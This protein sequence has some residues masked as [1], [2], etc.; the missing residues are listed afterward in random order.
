MGSSFPL[1]EDYRGRDFTVTVR[2]DLKALR[3]R[4]LLRWLL[5]REAKSEV[6]EEKAVLWVK[7]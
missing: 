4:E 3:G 7:P 1:G 2:W 6:T 5:Y